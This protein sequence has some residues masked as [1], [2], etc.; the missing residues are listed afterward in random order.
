MKSIHTLFSRSFAL[1]VGVA[2][3]R[4]LEHLCL[5]PNSPK[6][7]TA[8]FGVSGAEI[9]LLSI[10]KGD[11]EQTYSFSY[12]LAIGF[13]V[14]ACLDQGLATAVTLPV[15]VPRVIVK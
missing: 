9:P 7:Q 3:Y 2:E 6:F 4:S 15:S 12:L 13:V 11:T 1:P 10:P 14:P 5:P 8:A